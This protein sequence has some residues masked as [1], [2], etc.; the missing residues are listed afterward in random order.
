MVV[1]DVSEGRFHEAY[2]DIINDYSYVESTE[3]FYD[4]RNRYVEWTYGEGSDITSK[5]GH[6]KILRLN[7]KT[8]AITKHSITSPVIPSKRLGGMTLFN[9]AG[10]KNTMYYLSR[11]NTILGTTMYETLPYIKL[12]PEH[13]GAPHLNKQALYLHTFVRRTEVN[14][15]SAGTFD[16]ESGITATAW[17]DWSENEDDGKQSGPHDI[18][19]LLRLPADPGGGYPVALDYKPTI[20]INKTKIRGKGRSIQLQFDAVAGK[21]FQLMGWSLPIHMETK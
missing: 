4:E 12:W 20:I 2:L 3:G 7:L 16:N 14:W 10:E 9:K 21:D 19:R 13:L 6:T 5:Y 18:Y 1:Q 17:F 11:V 15:V 8:K